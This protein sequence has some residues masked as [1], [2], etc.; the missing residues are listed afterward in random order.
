M[1]ALGGLGCVSY[2]VPL[3]SPRFFRPRA[4]GQRGFM[5]LVEDV[6]AFVCVSAYMHMHVRSGMC[7]FVCHTVR[8]CSMQVAGDI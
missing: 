7:V 3:L 4:A 1:P 8:N 5:V 2:Q 6:H